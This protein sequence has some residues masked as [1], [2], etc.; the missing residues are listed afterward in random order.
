MKYD[1]IIIGSGSSGSVLATRLSEDAGRSVLLLEA[2]PDFPTFEELPEELKYSY[3]N[4][5]FRKGATFDWGYTGVANTHQKEPML[6]PRARVTTAE[7]NREF[8][9]IEGMAAKTISGSERPSDA[10]REDCRVVENRVDGRQNQQG[11]KGGRAQAAD[12][13]QPDGRPARGA[14]LYRTENTR[15]QKRRHHR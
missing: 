5:A 15:E 11:E 9:R 7:S 3:T 1:V 8:W 13:Y 12:D 14:S 6:V 2:G 10:A 4:Y